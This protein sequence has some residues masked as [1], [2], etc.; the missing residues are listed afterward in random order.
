M[1]YF[2]ASQDRWNYK[3]LLSCIPFLSLGLTAT[4]AMA[5]VTADDTLPVDTVVTP[6]GDVYEIT[7]G[8][9]Q[10][11]NLFHSF[12]QFSPGDSDVS[13]FTTETIDTVLGRVTGGLES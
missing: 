12:E 11:S 6:N 8:T 7:G 1:T 9:V 13:F 10:E 5:Q 3:L 2:L 4:A